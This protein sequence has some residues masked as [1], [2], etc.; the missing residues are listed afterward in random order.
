[1]PM[2]NQKQRI[3]AYYESNYDLGYDYRQDKVLNEVSIINELLFNKSGSIENN[4]TGSR[5]NRKNE[6]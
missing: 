2:Y 5:F 4:V 1:M 6:L 3:G